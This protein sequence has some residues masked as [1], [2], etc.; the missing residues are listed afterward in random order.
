MSI[1]NKLRERVF[2]AAGYRCGYCRVHADYVYAPMQIDHIIP[3]AHSGDDT[4]DN[5]WLACP[6]CNLHK[7]DKLDGID[8]ESNRSTALFNP[9]TQRW[10]EHF[11][12]QE[13][14]ATIVGK[15]AIGRATVIALRLNAVEAL[16]FRRLLVA[17]GWQPP[18][19]AT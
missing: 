4:E 8:P 2:M 15:T 10:S 5:L 18:E 11:I 19:D 16:R 17:A 9:R 3:T 14:N 1:S 13:D 12:W 7:A 6:R